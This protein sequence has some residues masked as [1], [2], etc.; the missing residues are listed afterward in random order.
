MLGQ[1]AH[2][3]QSHQTGK[4]A[5]LQVGANGG[6]QNH[7][8]HTVREMLQVF[9]CNGSA[10]P[11][12]EKVARARRTADYVLP[13]PLGKALEALN[14]RVLRRKTETRQ[15]DREELQV[16]GDVRFNPMKPIA[17]ATIAVN[18]YQAAA[19]FGTIIKSTVLV[20]TLFAHNIPHPT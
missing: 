20:S 12:A 5:L 6:V 4:P 8:V 15:G 1:W 14:A 19:Y 3:G 17:S 7:T 13:Q 16:T 9:A 18:G 11:V 10:D 2:A